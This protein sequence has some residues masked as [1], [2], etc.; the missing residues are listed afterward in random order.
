MGILWR[1]IASGSSRFVVVARYHWFLLAS[2]ISGLS[3]RAPDAE[4]VQA[5][6]IKLHDQL[7]IL[8]FLAV[9]QQCQIL[10]TIVVGLK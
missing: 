9:Y 2:A 1:S 7:T 10:T 6:R 4:L 5:L 3:S 8:L